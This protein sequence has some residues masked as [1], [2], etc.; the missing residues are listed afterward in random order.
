MGYTRT[1]SFRSDEDI[2]QALYYITEKIK[3]DVPIKE[4]TESNV[5]KGCII[6]IYLRMKQQD[7]V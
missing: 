5:I 7:K 4:L 2:D 3:Q 1:I 6:F